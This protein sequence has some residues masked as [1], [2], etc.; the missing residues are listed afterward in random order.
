MTKHITAKATIRGYAK[1]LLMYSS[2]ECVNFDDPDYGEPVIL[3]G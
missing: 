1:F 2:K 3:F